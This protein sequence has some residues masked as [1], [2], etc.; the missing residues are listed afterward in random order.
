M[1]IFHIATSGDWR[2]AL[3]SGVY[4][5]DSLQAEGF[6][7]CSTISQVLQVA[8]NLFAGQSN[9]VLLQIDPQ[10]VSSP[11]RYEDLY[12]AGE[13][14]PHIYGPLNLDAVVAAYDFL[15]DSEGDFQIPE[16]LVG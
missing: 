5:A 1:V 2:T 8:N 4:A 14:F 11:I 9:L 16:Q 10:R 15:P 12:H 3:S 13:L 7:H 6:I